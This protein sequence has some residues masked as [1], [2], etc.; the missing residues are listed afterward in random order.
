MRLRSIELIRDI[1]SALRRYPLVS[2]SFKQVPINDQ[3][4][5]LNDPLIDN[6]STMKSVKPLGSFLDSQSIS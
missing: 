1:V 3:L 6:A 4:E 5:P 2:D